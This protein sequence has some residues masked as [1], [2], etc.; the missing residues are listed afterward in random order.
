[1]T[2]GER[3]LG[4]SGYVLTWLGSLGGAVAGGILGYS[5]AGLVTDDSGGLET[6]L[7]L[8]FGVVAGGWVGAIVG[9]WFALRAGRR[10]F[11]SGTALIFG[12]VSVPVIIILGIVDTWLNQ[13]LPVAILIG[14]CLSVTGALARW[15][16]VGNE[17]DDP[18]DAPPEAAN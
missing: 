16:A 1:M 6:I 15:I 9:V 13:V 7:D 5:A 18:F 17:K 4:I 2:M 11:A 14:V 10:R 12:A 8:F 3:G